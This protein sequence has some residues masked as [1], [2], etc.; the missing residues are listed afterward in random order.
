MPNF[1]PV[2]DAVSDTAH[3][4]SEEMFVGVDRTPAKLTIAIPTYRRPDLL[5]QAVA[6][7]LAQDWSEPFE[8]IVVDNDPASDGCARLRT[9]VPGIAAANFRY[10]RNCQNLGM[11][12]NHNRCVAE[13]RSEWITIL[14]DDD[15]LDSDW[16]RR[17]FAQLCSDPRIDGLVCRKRVVDE[18][19]VPF[20][21][22]RLGRVARKAQSLAQFGLKPTRVIDARKL[23]WGCVTGN[24]VG[25]VCRT[26]HIRALGGF[27]PEEHPSSDYW[28]Y[29]RFAARYRLA[30]TKG[31]H[32]SICGGVNSLQAPE[33]QISALKMG[34]RLQQALAGSLLPAYFARLIPA[35]MSRQIAV[36]SRFWESELVERDVHAQLGV[37][38]SA[39]PA[40]ILHLARAALR[41]L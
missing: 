34:Y 14:H 7:A 22:S 39:V 36:T 28:F 12:P 23:F 26:S 18:R 29:A 33:T 8:V 25:F 15:L 37:P 13:A 24:T 27:Y 3:I 9:A 32:A 35:L 11:F 10:L 16:A 1:L 6:S 20:R 38:K 5:A 19:A 31:T 30:E 4:A 40:T 41:G 17:M 2:R 21:H